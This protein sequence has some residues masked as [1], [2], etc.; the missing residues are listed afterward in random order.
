M[1]GHVPVPFSP[2][3]MQLIGR[4][5]TSTVSV[6]ELAKLVTDAYQLTVTMERDMAATEAHFRFQTQLAQFEH[7]EI[8]QAMALG[9][10]KQ[11]RAIDMIERI[12]SQLIAR[13]QFEMAQTIV[14]QMIELIKV[15]PV[16]D[17]YV[18]RTPK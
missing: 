7:E 6:T 18:G 11:D 1:T 5:V 4:A 9:F 10:L 8:M 3:N 12:T 13:E 14:T 2:S 17:A 15:S 16:K